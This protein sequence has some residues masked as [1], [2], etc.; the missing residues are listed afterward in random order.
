LNSVLVVAKLN[1][2]QIAPWP[3]ALITLDSIKPCGESG[4]LS[5]KRN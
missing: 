2:N 3:A 4:S 1:F 5:W